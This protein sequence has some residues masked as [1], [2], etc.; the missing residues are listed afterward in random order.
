MSF[1]ECKSLK[2]TRLFILFVTILAVST[3]LGIAIGSVRIGL[4]ELGQIIFHHLTQSVSGLVVWKIRMP[5]VFSTTLSGAYLAISGLL[6]QV[7][8]RNPIVGPYVLGLSSGA[9]LL[10]ALVMLGGVS[11]GITAIHPFLISLAAF[12]GALIV[13]L[14]ITIVAAKVRSIVTLLIIGLMVG[15][16]CFAITSIL[17][18]FAEKERIKGFVLWQ[19][20]SFSGF[21]WKELSVLVLLGIPLVVGSCLIT[22][23]MNALLLGEDY[24]K[25]MGVN[26]K[27]LRCLIIVFASGLAGLVTAFS[28]PVAFV[29]L[30]VPHLARLFFGTADNRTLVP[31]AAVLGAIVTTL[32]DLVARTILSPV[33]LPIGA[34]T[35]FFGAPIVISMLLKKRPAI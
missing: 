4:H 34:I 13:T 30:A 23:P 6:L 2:K 25:T 9:T 33:E 32:C 20:G 11:I 24:A 29:G 31:G 12:T 18:T 27:S 19:L 8:F 35:S 5:R 28:G 14:V 15:Y 22:K 21:S 10:V 7:F 26:T 16:L 1:R 3:G 17:V